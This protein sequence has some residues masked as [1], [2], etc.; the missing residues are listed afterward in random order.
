MTSAT[1]SSRPTSAVAVIDLPQPDSPSRAR[2]SP[3]RAS[4]RHVVD[5]ADGAADGADVDGQAVDLEHGLGVDLRRR[6]A[7]DRLTAVIRG[8]SW[9]W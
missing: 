2:V 6:W 8:P 3:R 5:G 7:C 9:S 4:K 1:G